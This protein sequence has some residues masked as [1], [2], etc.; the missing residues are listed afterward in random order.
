MYI[1]NLESLRRS[2][3]TGND[4]IYF[5][6]DTSGSLSQPL[7]ETDGKGNVKAEYTRTE[8]W[9][10][11]QAYNYYYEIWLTGEKGMSNI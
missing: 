6:S 8:S 1:Y 10:Y 3:T 2:K 9:Q 5:V 11:S 4:S 7:A